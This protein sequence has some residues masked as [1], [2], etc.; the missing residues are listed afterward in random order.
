[1]RKQVKERL[2]ALGVDCKFTLKKV[3]F[4]DLARGEAIF[5]KLSETIPPETYRAAKQS[6]S[7]IGIIL[8]S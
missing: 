7:E 8:P 6:L 2:A 4:C 1:M 3:S 5:C